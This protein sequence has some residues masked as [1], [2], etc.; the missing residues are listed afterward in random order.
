VLSLIIG[1]F[2]FFLYTHDLTSNPPGFYV[3]EATFAYNAYS[4]ATTGAGEFGVRWPLFFQH[5]DRPFTIYGNP[6][7]TYLLAALFL[8]FPPSIWLARLLSAL[9][10]FAAGVLMGFL[11]FKISGKRS[12]G[13]I[14]GMTALLTPWFFEFS[15][16]FSDASY[17]PLVLTL[18][19]LALYR[20]S[21]KSKWSWQDAVS[22]GVALGFV[23]YTYS[24]GRLLGPL[25]AAGLIC[26]AVNRERLVGL[27]K[28]WLVYALTLAPLFIFYLR[29]PN[30][31]SSRFISVSYLRTEPTLSRIVV[32]FVSRYFQDLS[33]VGLLTT[34]DVNPRHHVPGATGSLLVAT[35]VLALIGIL[36]LLIR[37]RE[38]PW[39]RY[40]VFGT[41]ASVIPGALTI[42]SFHTGRMI[43]Y[44][45]FL[46]VLTVPAF[47]WLSEKSDRS[48][49][50]ANEPGTRRRLLSRGATMSL[51]RSALVFLVVATI[52]QAA[53]FQ[54][55]FWRDGY[56]RRYP[57]D[58]TYKEAYDWATQL[59]TRPIYLEDG[60]WGPGYIH[61][62]WY[63]TLEGRSKTEFVHLPY[64]AQPP[65]GALVISSEEKCMNCQILFDNNHYKVFRKL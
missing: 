59:P 52:A 18:F 9:V 60:K 55:L 58:A 6:V 45:V 32:R 47:Q 1:P 43:A 5:F 23:T 56:S 21:L 8:F 46:L 49:H 22:I 65:A 41:F 44:P 51:K 33:L 29:Q 62:L 53:Y 14:V 31:V 16:W 12:I 26:F 4:I 61:A 20:A 38:D 17:Y 42:D 25:L 10:G 19:L 30:A 57:W 2:L 11:A 35:F 13:V 40:I 27:V 37:H 15:R 3:D 63:A 24:I 48:R 28:T 50:P 39:W 7:H 54:G 34:G 64:R 36:V